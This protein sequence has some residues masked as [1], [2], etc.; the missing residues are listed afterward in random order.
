MNEFPRIERLPPYIFAVVGDL[1]MQL[2]RQG[3]D[4]ID[5]SM[6]NPDM[7]TPPHIVDKLVEAARRPVNHRYSVSKGIPNLRKAICDRYQ[8]YYDVYLDPNTEAVVTMGSKEGLAHL[9]LA[10]LSPGDVV[11]TPDP[12]Y[13][14]HTYAPIIAG[15]DVRRVPI[16][17]G[18]DFFE[19][20]LTATRQAWPKPKVLFLCYPHNPTTEVATPEFFQKIV[21]FAKEHHIWVLHDLAYADLSF[22][23]YKAPSFL[24]AEGAKDVG[25][26]FS[27]LSKSYAMAGWR[28]G[29]C[30]GNRELIHAL[31]RIKSYLDYGIFQPVQIASTV[32]LN[33]PD[34]CVNEI[35][36]IYQKRRDVLVEGLNRIGWEMTSPKATMFV[37]ARIPEP[38]RKMGSVE[39]SKLLLKEARV[40]VSPGL[41]F[42]SYGDDYVRIAL[43]ENEKRIRQAIRGIRRMLG[44]VDDHAGE[45]QEELEN[46]ENNA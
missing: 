35:R 39:F 17:P 37:W 3:V 6:G 28:V 46:R 2:R 40:A 10:M 27:T 20:L 45:E 12:T 31:T 9:S 7:P 24:Q 13:P 22:D 44:G 33:G 29:F 8:R 43:I 15:A 30:V 4:I 1:K 21:E 23:G 18:R 16:G 41:G 36:D 19:D 34:E 14:I 26:E 11:L 42:G 5:F 38:F 32:A 25:V